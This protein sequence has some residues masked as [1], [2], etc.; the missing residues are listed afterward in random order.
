MRTFACNAP[1]DQGG[2][3]RALTSLVEEARAAGDLASYFC[4]APK[5]ND[6]AGRPIDLSR[7]RW[8]LRGM[9][10]GAPHGWRDYAAADLFDRAVSRRLG[11]PRVF[12]G[13][14]GRA[15]RSFRRARRARVEWLVLEASNSH[16][17]NVERQQRQAGARWG[18]EPGWLTPWHATRYRLEYEEA[19]EIMVTSEYARRSFVEAG[20]DERKVRRRVQTI[21]PRFAPPPVRPGTDR[22]TIVYVGRLEV[23]KGIPLLL[24]AF[25]ALDHRDAELRLVGACASRA[26]EA[27]LD[28][29]RAA[30]PRIRVGFGD[31]LP[32]LHRADVLVHPSYEDGLG[33]AP[34]EAL[35]C[36]VPVIVTDQTG[37]KEYVQEGRN[38]FVVAAG[39]V[40]ATV[41]RL[42]QVL[43]RPL[44]GSFPPPP[45]AAS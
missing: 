29:R 25:Q 40:N 27:L 16:V 8:L 12:V 43:A 7:H 41:D 30:D 24:D 38:G 31:P 37:M 2:L 11:R 28:R 20:V 17:A 14:A 42:R 6:P 39:D 26:M 21:S 10:R 13:F 15:L 23:T 19:D 32:H 35:A 44:R 4:S 45:I 36:G 3:G 22:F 5:A 1:W 34:L 9:L 18:I 33:L